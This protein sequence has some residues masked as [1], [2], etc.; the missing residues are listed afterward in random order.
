MSDSMVFTSSRSAC[1]Y[2][3]IKARSR[4]VCTTYRDIILLSAVWSTCIIRYVHVLR[5]VAD[6]CL[7]V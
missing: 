1:L 4:S 3:K 7:N 6:G 5:L 2:N